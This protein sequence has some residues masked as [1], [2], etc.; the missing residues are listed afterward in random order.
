MLYVPKVRP[1]YADTYAVD[2]ANERFFMGS[3]FI[4]F[5]TGNRDLFHLSVKVHT[6]PTLWTGRPFPVL[7]IAKKET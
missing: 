1:C 7:R 2:C 4:V 6:N 3:Y 5:I